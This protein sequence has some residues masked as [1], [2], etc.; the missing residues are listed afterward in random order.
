MTK[1]HN[2]LNLKPK[3][4]GV[5]VVPPVPFELG[6]QNINRTD[7]DLNIKNLHVVTDNETSVFHGQKIK[8]RKILSGA[9]PTATLQSNDYA[10]AI[11]DIAVARTITLPDPVIA[12]AG[13]VFIVKDAT[14]SCSATTITISPYST[15]TIDGDTS[16]KLNFD[17][18]SVGFYTDGSNWFSLNGGLESAPDRGFQMVVF[19]FTTSVATGDGKFYLHIDP[20]LADHN[21]IDGH[22]EVITAGVSGTTSVQ[23]HNVTQAVDI[24]AEKIHIDSGETGSDT[25]ATAYSV[26]TSNDYMTENDL[27]RVDVDAV[28]SEVP[29]GLI[30]TLGFRKDN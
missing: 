23:V 10:L 16:Y 27:L 15:E 20:R 29:A 26:N 8:V 30:V 28:Q 6:V 2:Q 4:S 18:G 24:F 7:K 3:E 12:G 17:Y 22:A 1:V 11:H 14:G 13:K 19:D 21:L 9:S 5:S 25:A